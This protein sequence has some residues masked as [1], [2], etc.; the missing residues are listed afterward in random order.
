ME[1]RWFF[2]GYLG[3]RTSNESLVLANESS[4]NR[5]TKK[6]IGLNTNSGYED[7]SAIPLNLSLLLHN[8]GASQFILELISG[9]ETSTQFF[10][11]FIL[12]NVAKLLKY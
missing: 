5:V 4:L 7:A 6:W 8:D 1:S 10:Q 3:I 12:R 2:F 11:F 9:M